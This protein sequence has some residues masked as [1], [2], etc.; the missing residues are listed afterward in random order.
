MNASLDYRQLIDRAL[1]DAGVTYRDLETL[2]MEI[3]SDP[4][5]ELP[6]DEG[7][8]P[9]ALDCFNA[10]RELED[11]DGAHPANQAKTLDET[12]RHTE[13]AS[14]HLK[15]AELFAANARA[16][17]GTT[18]DEADWS[19]SELWHAV[20]SLLAAE[21]PLTAAIIARRIGDE[22]LRR[23]AEQSLRERLK[24]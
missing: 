16:G 11:D 21:R 1:G 20:N 7:S 6:A 3:G 2:L 15:A 10:I 23:E 9:A 24:T 8:I 22:D 4:Y 18:G 19:Q 17:T 13:A 14:L 12:G 5:G